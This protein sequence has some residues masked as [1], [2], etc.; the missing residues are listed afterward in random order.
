MAE[1]Q[2]SSMCRVSSP[3]LYKKSSETVTRS[4]HARKEPTREICIM[5]LC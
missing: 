1:T 3:I 4:E 5:K 2:V